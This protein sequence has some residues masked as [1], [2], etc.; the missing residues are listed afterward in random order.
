[1]QLASAAVLCAGC[2]G[3]MRNRPISDGPARASVLASV[4]PRQAMPG[5]GARQRMTVLTGPSSEGQHAV[6]S[7]AES[8]PLEEETVT[9][10]MDELWGDAGT[11]HRQKKRLAAEREAAA[12][13]RADDDAVI[14]AAVD[15]EDSERPVPTVST[16]TSRGLL[17][18]DIGGKPDARPLHAK[19]A[20]DRRMPGCYDPACDIDGGPGVFLFYDD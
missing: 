14:A 10:F 16:T 2:A 9:E 4:S 13:E 20:V 7:W 1:V 19:H 5:R 15:V 8:H 18:A 11:K 17:C 6:D 3:W 12:E